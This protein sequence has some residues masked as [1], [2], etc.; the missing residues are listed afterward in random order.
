MAFFTKHDKNLKNP[1]NKNKR[2]L[3]HKLSNKLGVGNTSYL[4]RILDYTQASGLSKWWCHSQ[5][6]ENSR[7]KIGMNGK[8]DEF[9][10][11]HTEFKFILGISNGNFYQRVSYMGLTLRVRIWT[12]VKFLE[13]IEY[14]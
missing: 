14:K 1:R 13:G 8:H 11:V 9:N 7:V 12:G 3:S 4:G 10:F 5:R 2:Y 6:K